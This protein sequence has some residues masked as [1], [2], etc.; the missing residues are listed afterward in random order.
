MRVCVN[1]LDARLVDVRMGVS[2]GVVGVLMLV[3]DVVVVMRG[4]RMDVGLVLV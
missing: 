1:V 2:L 3:L 4:M